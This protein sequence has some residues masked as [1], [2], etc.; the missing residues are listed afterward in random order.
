MDKV[1]TFFQVCHATDQPL[2][3]QQHCKSTAKKEIKEANQKRDAANK[4]CAASCRNN[5]LSTGNDKPE[6]HG[7]T[8]NLCCYCKLD[9]YDVTWNSC[10]CHNV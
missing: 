2:H 4:K 6:K 3:D 8:E 7:C 9:S 10:S 5:S 1:V